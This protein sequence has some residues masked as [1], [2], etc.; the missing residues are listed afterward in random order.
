MTYLDTRRMRAA[1]KQF[2]KI[3]DQAA[4][5]S[6]LDR[7]MEAMEFADPAW[8]YLLQLRV[9]LTCTVDDLL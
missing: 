7:R 2:A 3:T 9:S 4:F 6:W 1:R 5:I 8:E